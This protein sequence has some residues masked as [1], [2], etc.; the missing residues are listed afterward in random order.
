MQLGTGLS[1]S[2][3]DHLIVSPAGG[4]GEYVVPRHA[5]DALGRHGAVAVRRCEADDV[6]D[7]DVATLAMASADPGDFAHHLH[8]GQ[9]GWAGAEGR[10]EEVLEE[11]VADAGRLDEEDGIVAGAL[12]AGKGPEPASPRHTGVPELVEQS[13]G[14]GSGCD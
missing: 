1:A 7:P 13:C 4:L 8:G 14:L 3:L 10:I 9:H 6:P 5:N 11:E 2:Y 12:D